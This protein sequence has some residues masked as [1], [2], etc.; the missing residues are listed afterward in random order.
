MNK[1]ILILGTSYSGGVSVYVSTLLKNIQNYSFFVPCSKAQPLKAIDRL[2]PNSIQ[3]NFNQNYSFYSLFNKAQELDAVVKH[4]QIDI[5]HAHVLKFGL[6]AAFYKKFINKKIKL[7]YTGHGSRHLQKKRMV[8]KLIFKYIEKFV[9]HASDRIIFIRALEYNYSI[10]IGLVCRDKARLIKTQVTLPLCNLNANK[11]REEYKLPSKK[12][13]AMIGKIYD[14]KNPFLFCTIAEEVLKARD[15]IIFVWIGD[16]PLLRDVSM[17]IKKLG[18]INKVRFIGP[19]GY[20]K[21]KAAWRDIDI[22]LLTSRIEIFPIIALEAYQSHALVI[23]TN[24]L[25]VKEV[26]DDGVTGY[27]FNQEAP[28][29]AVQKIIS[30]VDHPNTIKNITNNAFKYYSDNFSSVDE[31]AKEHISLY[32]EI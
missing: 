12:I 29:E 5:I 10:D 6:L 2:F 11:F 13:V 20:E 15:D 18:L 30:T 19:I 24:F 1:K 25:G 27:I 22:L 23:S 3:Y 8:H 7:V 32:E 17:H 28:N 21:M 14:I 4:H 9:N 16:G 26:I 31:M